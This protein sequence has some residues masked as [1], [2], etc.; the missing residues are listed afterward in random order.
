MNAKKVLLLAPLLLL[1]GC[2][3]DDLCFGSGQ[4]GFSTNPLPE[5]ILNQAYLGT[6]QMSIAGNPNDDAYTYEVTTRGALPDGLMVLDSG[7]EIDIVGTP[8]ATGTFQFSLT[9][10]VSDPYAT[11]EDLCFD[12]VTRNF[13]LVVADPGA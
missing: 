4:P 6:V 5:A 3:E 13:R 7:R 11:Q 12:T 8:V 9:M 10:K 2:D 1:A